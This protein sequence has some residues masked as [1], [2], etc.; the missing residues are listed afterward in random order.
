MLVVIL[1]VVIMVEVATGL[2]GGGVVGVRM[3][4]EAPGEVVERARVGAGNGAVVGYQGLVVEVEGNVRGG[5]YHF[6]VFQ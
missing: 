4:V 1:V 6:S 3:V 2:V 5:V